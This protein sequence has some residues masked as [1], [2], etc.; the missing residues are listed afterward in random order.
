[1][2][3]RVER[4]DD[5]TVKLAVTVERPRVTRALDD[6][7][8]HL[9]EEVKVP[10]FRKG[11]VPR[12][13]LESRLGKGAVVQHAVQ[14]SL[15]QFYAEAVREQELEPVGQPDFELG[16][17]EE[18]E[19]ASF[20]ATVEVRPDFDA[21]SIDGILVTHPEWEVGDDDVEEELNQ[22]RER[23]AEAETVDRPIQVDDLAVL[24]ISAAHAG[25]PVE[26][27]SMDDQLYRVGDPEQTGQALDRELLGTAAG[28]IVKFTDTFDGVD[29]RELDFTVIVK[30]VKALRLPEADD[31]FAIT[32]SEFDTI[33]ELREGIREQLAASKLE[34]ARGALRGRAVETIS[35]LVEV[36]LPRALVDQEV[37]FQL[38]RLARD[39]E[40]RQIP[41]DQYV[42]AAGT[43]IEE[44]QQQLEDNARKTVR[45]QLVVD[46][47]GRDAGIEVTN[48]DLT[49]QVTEE[50]ARL[51]MP[52]QELAQFMS[53]PER[54]GVLFTDAFRRKT[55]DY[56]IDHV[57]VVDAPP[58]DG[59]G[60]EAATG[61][62]AD[63]PA[64]AADADAAADDAEPAQ[65]SAG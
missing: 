27:A 11:R 47:I 34:L 14:D 56:I 38:A 62:G 36:P 8:R 52:P 3:T 31:D 46:R 58:D 44:L 15:P 60:D 6:A 55:I 21:P 12:K 19:D 5:T 53:E 43:T 9:A 61:P 54:L 26:D 49:R 35:E 2:D 7:A 16:T 24:T 18:G 37:Q 10:G 57:E 41:F 33:D 63:A 39:A 51:N 20:T 50:A 40:R 64:D 28:G 25:T 30:D 32:A 29:D 22:L 23:F 42:Q 13:V 4:V 45:A 1:M 59:A 17:F 48:E 65:P